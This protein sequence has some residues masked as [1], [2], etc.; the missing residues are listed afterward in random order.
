MISR[1]ML[2]WSVPMWTKSKEQSVLQFRR[3][4]NLRHVIN[5]FESIQKMLMTRN[6][7]ETNSSLTLTSLKRVQKESFFFIIKASV[8]LRE[9]FT[10]ENN[11][12]KVFVHF[13]SSPK[14]I[15]K[16]TC[17]LRIS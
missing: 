2:M 9:S 4:E 17:T 12:D 6:K 1:L 11:S 16:K 13:S 3:Y 10:K 7:K 5:Y 14:H 8:Q 15:I